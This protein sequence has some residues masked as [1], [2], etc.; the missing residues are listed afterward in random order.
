M[1]EGGSGNLLQQFRQRGGAEMI[2]ARWWAVPVTSGAATWNACNLAWAMWW[3]D[4]D[5]PAPI[6]FA[7]FHGYCGA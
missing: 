4:G 5:E 7:Q 3:F 2:D 1:V 6:E